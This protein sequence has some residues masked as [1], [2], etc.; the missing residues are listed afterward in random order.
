MTPFDVSQPQNADWKYR[1]GALMAIS[2]CGEG[3]H[4]QMEGMLTNIVEAILPFLSDSV[5]F[6]PFLVVAL[7]VNN[8]QKFCYLYTHHSSASTCQYLRRDAITRECK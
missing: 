7:F 4:K 3:C 1:H 6:P 5:R 8:L 2:A